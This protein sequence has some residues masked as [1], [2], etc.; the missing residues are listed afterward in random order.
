LLSSLLRRRLVRKG[1]DLSI[2]KILATLSEIKEVALFSAA[3][4]AGRR[5][6]LI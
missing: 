3:R 1:I 6:S 5:L 4:T 2:V